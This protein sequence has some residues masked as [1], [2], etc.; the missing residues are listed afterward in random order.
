LPATQIEVPHGGVQIVVVL[1]HGFKV[2]SKMKV[3]IV[4]DTAQMTSLIFL[5]PVVSQG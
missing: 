1:N 5:I 3:D 2:L 4:E